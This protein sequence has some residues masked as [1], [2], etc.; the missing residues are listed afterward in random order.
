M[1]VRA[2]QDV[3]VV[4]REHEVDHIAAQG[5][6]VDSVRFGHFDARPAAVSELST[7][8][9]HLLV[10][11]KA[12]TLRE[13]LE[14]V[15][16]RP[17]LI[18]P[19]LNGLEHVAL[20]RGHFAGSRVGAGTIR[21]EADRPSPGRIVHSSPG[22]RIELAA[23]DPFAHDDLRALAQ[24]LKRAEIPA[25]IGVSEAQV[26][27]SKLV[28]LNALAITTSAAG[29]PI[30]QLRGDPQWRAVL[31]ACV[32]ETAAVANADGATVDPASSL[33]E[34][35]S[36]HPGLGSSMQRDLAA[37]RR[38]ELDAIAG[39]V[40]RAAARHGLQCPTVTRLAGVIAAR[41]GIAAPELARPAA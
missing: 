11:T 34:L 41:A 39:A 19:L 13:A 28:R 4:G 26:L 10:A 1:L 12:T 14:R 27:W 20:L 16:V 33:A 18:V 21:M 36:A 37:G 38:P 23:D 22:V 24:A 40:M 32:E 9:D 31:I 6:S 3:V 29:A 5:I 30:G 2:G 7:P 17:R 35:D 25:E 15:R 8:V